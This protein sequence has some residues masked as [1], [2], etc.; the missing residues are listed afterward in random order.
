MNNI[1]KIKKMNKLKLVHILIIGLIITSVIGCIDDGDGNLISDYSSEGTETD[2]GSGCRGRNNGTKNSDALSIGTLYLPYA[3]GTKHNLG[4]GWF[5]SYSHNNTG[6]EHALDFDMVDGVTDIH[7][8]KSG[9]V[10]AVKEDSNTTCSSNCSDANYVE[11]DHGNGFYA[12]YLHFAYNSVDVTVGQ[13]INSS[14]YIL[15]KA[16]NTGWST[17]PHLHFEIVDFEENCTV[18]YTFDTVG[19]GG[20]LTTGTEYTS[21]YVVPGAAPILSKLTGAV[22]SNSGL[23]LT[24]GFAWKQTGGGSF[25]ISGTTTD[26][27]TQIK[28]VILTS[29]DGD[30]LAG[31]EQVSDATGG[32][33]TNISYTVPSSPGNYYISISSSENGSWSYYNPPRFVIQ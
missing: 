14:T 13:E 25:T 8:V 20:N 16:G 26:G 11:I 15:G 28:I 21:T 27:K 12:K 22:F 6:A 10:M 23:N 9:T 3:N 5:G 17:N 4:Q 29:L 30:I 1:S 32:T 7:A 33:F 19:S 24:S 2:S 18:E 31:S